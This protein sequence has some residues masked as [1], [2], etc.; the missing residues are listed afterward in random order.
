MSFIHSPQAGLV[1]ACGEGLRPLRYLVQKVFQAAGLQA[2]P[3]HPLGLGGVQVREDGSIVVPVDALVRELERVDEPEDVSAETEAGARWAGRP[4]PRKHPGGQQHSQGVLR[5]RAC[6]DAPRGPQWGGGSTLASSTWAP[7]RRPGSV[8]GRT[9]APAF[10]PP[11]ASVSRSRSSRLVAHA[12]AGGRPRAF[13]SAR[14]LFVSVTLTLGLVL[15]LGLAVAGPRVAPTPC[16]PQTPSQSGQRHCDRAFVLFAGDLLFKMS[17]ECGA[18]VLSGVPRARWPSRGAQGSL[19][20]PAGVT[21]ATLGSVH[22][23]TL[24]HS[25]PWKQLEVLTPPRPP[26]GVTLFTVWALQPLEHSAGC[27]HPAVPK[28]RLPVVQL[29][30]LPLCPQRGPSV[31]RTGGAVDRGLVVGPLWALWA[32]G[33]WYRVCLC[34]APGS[35][36]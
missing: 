14:L 19:V 7:G 27:T 35:G 9:G 28:L 36:G 3:G 18:R 4:A 33:S 29:L 8:S 23:P 1:Q 31:V 6:G 10:R 20:S 26:L 13:R 25:A 30:C 12:Q 11:A 15:L 32:L 5:D 16:L 22:G 24:V 17:P 21:A 2:E 34:S